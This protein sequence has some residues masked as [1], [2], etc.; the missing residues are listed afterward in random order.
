MARRSSLFLGM[1]R[2]SAKQHECKLLRCELRRPR[3]GKPSGPG[4]RTCAPGTTMSPGMTAKKTAEDSRYG[5]EQFRAHRYDQLHEAAS[6]LRIPHCHHDNEGY[7]QQCQD[8]F[9][10]W[11]HQLPVASRIAS[12]N[13]TVPFSGKYDPAGCSRIALKSRL[14]RTFGLYSR[15]RGMERATTC[16]GAGPVMG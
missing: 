7:H 2:Y 16:T 14:R 1:R 5:I 8:Q 12:L 11:A 4:R 6:P 9:P 3:D 15:R 13:G 10:Q